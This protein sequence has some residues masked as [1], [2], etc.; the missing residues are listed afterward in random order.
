MLD[1]DLVDFGEL[2]EAVNALL[3]QGVVAYRSSAGEADAL[4]RQALSLAPQALPVYYCLYKT[5]TYRGNL[6]EALC[7]AQAGRK[8]AARQADWPEDFT[9]WQPVLECPPGPGRFALYTLK[10]LAFIHLRRAEPEQAHRILGALARIDPTASVGWQVIADLARSGKDK[11]RSP[12][13]VCARA[14]G[15]H[16]A[17]Q[18]EGQGAGRR[19]DRPGGIHGRGLERGLME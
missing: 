16:P 2:P 10:A 4:F 11:W 18:A 8:E 17:G 9:R 5:H 12:E 14:A 6:D 1:R 3:Q 15:A 7:A 19:P 13:K